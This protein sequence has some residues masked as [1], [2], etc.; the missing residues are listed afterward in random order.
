MN[1]KTLLWL[2]L[3]FCGTLAF[4]WMLLFFTLSRG[5]IEFAPHDRRAGEILLPLAAFFGLLVVF[6]AIGIGLYI[7]RDARRRGMEPLLW[8]LAAVFIPYFLGLIIYL[9]V[10]QPFQS[11]CPSCASRAPLNASFCPSCGRPILLTCPK[12]RTTL[13]NGA[14]FCHA[15]GAE[16]APR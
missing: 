7:Y 1:R 12:C 4:A 9:I 16:A 2:S 14:R 15:C 5:W 8:T 11:V 3:G 13:Q 6:T 10:R